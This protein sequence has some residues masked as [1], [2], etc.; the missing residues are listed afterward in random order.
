MGQ[1]AAGQ[2]VI[3]G[4]FL[5]YATGHYVFTKNYHSHVVSCEGVRK[6][7]TMTGLYQVP[8]YG[9][10]SFMLRKVSVF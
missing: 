2:F 9:G 6:G 3:Q 10:D 5:N 1:D 7:M 4:R 8:G